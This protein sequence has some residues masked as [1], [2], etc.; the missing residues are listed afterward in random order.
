MNDHWHTYW[1]NS[2][3]TGMPTEVLWHLPDG[4]QIEEVYESPPVLHE[5]EGLVDY[6]HEDS[7][8][9]MAR[10]RIDPSL[11]WSQ[12]IQI[13][14]TVDW[15]ECATLCVPGHSEL[16]LNLTTDTQIPYEFAKQV[17]TLVTQYEDTV[18]GTFG[19][20][21]G[22][23]AFELPLDNADF[24]AIESAYFFPEIAI[25][26]PTAVQIVDRTNE[27]LLLTTD[28]N[29][30]NVP[31]DNEFYGWL[32]LKNPE[33]PEKNSSKRYRLIKGTVAIA[34]APNSNTGSEMKNRA[35]G[36]LLLLLP[37][38][39]LGGLILNLMPCV[40]PVIGLKI[41]GF[42][43][44]AG[45]DRKKII[46]HGLVFTSGVL[47]SFWLLSAL[48]LILRA[49][50][51]QLGWGFQLQEPWFNYGL[52]LL[53]LAFAL[54][55][56]G[57]FEFG[58]SAIGVGSGLQH[59]S[60][61]MGS[62]FSGILATVVATPCS[63]PFLAPALG[64]ALALEPWQA[65]I[66][67]TCIALGLSTPYLLLSLFPGIINRLP[68]PGAWMETFKQFMAFP[69][70]G[71][72]A[73]LL[74]A[75]LGQIDDNSQLNLLLSLT[76]F[77]MALWIFGRW[78]APHRSLIVRRIAVIFSILLIAI[79]ILLGHPKA[80]KDFWEPWSPETVATYVAEGRTVYVD[81]TAR[82]CATCQLN[83]RV[84]FGSK[85]VLDAFKQQKIVALKAD[86]TN[87][88]DRI[89]AQLKTL[90]KAAV[91]VNL[92]YKNGENEP[93]ILPEVLTPDIVLKAL[94][95]E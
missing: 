5:N 19:I 87:R 31:S 68:R 63:A 48:L 77:A 85:D 38:A 54:S 13:G 43:E 8:I 92:V 59:K 37:L 79:S 64:A 20:Q 84:V 53:M 82:W 80:K 7:S 89:T 17:E 39:F 32:I 49:G 95:S 62:F 94:T 9:V 75:L 11:Q 4:M 90:G 27:S 55:L 6:V 61:V 24:D 23:V 14:A 66:L 18:N 91:P 10:I 72:V 71:T 88:D 3:T 86:W 56:N 51:Q 15:L 93:V 41:M 26:D 76:V 52:I 40:F 42:V 30:Y 73:Y 29:P 78:G 74:W 83:K 50:G 35:D 34:H 25:S 21:G 28:I 67:F 47:L 65:M 69:L 57:V 60:G 16:S 2:G 12:T 81:F 1:K 46:L 36:S 45:Q 44:Q 58:M 33:N 22:K 70:Y